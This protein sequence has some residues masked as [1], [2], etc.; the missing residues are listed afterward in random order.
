MR[1]TAAA[2]LVVVAAWAE[3][4]GGEGVGG[5]GGGEGGGGRREVDVVVG[6]EGGVEVVGQGSGVAVAVAVEREQVQQRGVELLV[7]A[8]A[9]VVVGR[10]EEGA[11]LLHALVQCRKQHTQVVRQRAA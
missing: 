2:L 11:P 3:S 5:R 7:E 8:V 6:V 4:A 9:G 10:E 1:E